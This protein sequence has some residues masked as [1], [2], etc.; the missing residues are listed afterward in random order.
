MSP[1]ERLVMSLIESMGSSLLPPMTRIL[2][3]RRSSWDS[4]LMDQA[5]TSSTEATLATPSTTLGPMMLTPQESSL[6]T[7]SLM[8]GFSAM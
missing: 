3:P 5:T 1:E 8:A 6:P 4:S 7:F 2:L